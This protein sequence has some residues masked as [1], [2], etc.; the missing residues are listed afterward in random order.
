VAASFQ[1]DH[2]ADFAPERAEE[3]LR[4]I[5]T[6]PGVFALFGAR[7]GDAPYLTR[8]ADLR[9]RVRR[10]RLRDAAARAGSSAR[11]AYGQSPR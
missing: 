9:R 2:I 7:D 4:E 10:L 8:T 5:P 3:I 1:F 11:S 6:L